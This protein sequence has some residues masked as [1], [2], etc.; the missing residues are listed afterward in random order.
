M[1]VEI[2]RDRCEIIGGNLF[3][4]LLIDTADVEILHRPVKMWGGNFWR[5]PGRSLTLR[6]GP[7]S[8]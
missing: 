4:Y 2:N 3:E 8:L 6:I 5:W 1:A 7:W